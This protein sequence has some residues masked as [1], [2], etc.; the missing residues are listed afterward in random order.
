[1]TKFGWF[2][3]GFGRKR[4]EFYDE[5]VIAIRSCDGKESMI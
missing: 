2:A 3:A 4:T 5:S 1:M